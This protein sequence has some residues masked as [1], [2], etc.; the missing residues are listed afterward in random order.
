M[1]KV[2]TSR[3]SKSINWQWMWCSTCFTIP[4]I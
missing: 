2:A 1:R 3:K 4:Y